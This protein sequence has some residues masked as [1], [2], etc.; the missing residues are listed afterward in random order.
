MKN[1][2]IHKK[3]KTLAALGIVCAFLFFLLTNC[4]ASEV[5]IHSIKLERRE[6]ENLYFRLVS[7]IDFFDK[8]ECKGQ[9]CSI[10]FEFYPID[11]KDPKRRV[12]IGRS[13][14]RITKEFPLDESGVKR[15]FDF[16]L[17][18]SG[19]TFQIYKA[20]EGETVEEERLSFLG[21]RSDGS[22]EYLLKIPMEMGSF[23]GENWEDPSLDDENVIESYV[24][25]EGATYAFWGRIVG[26]T[27]PFTF[28]F[29][30]RIFPYFYLGMR[31]RLYRL[32]VTIPK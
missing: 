30:Y 1:A 16:A 26:P 12:W 8:R 5:K 7:D 13:P 23:G 19:P 17:R 20:E 24:L 14:N 4:L 25:K 10:R 2:L 3:R 27:F 15:Q 9:R 11:T 31:S 28:G 29:A 18:Y 21:F 6:A 32:E 22:F